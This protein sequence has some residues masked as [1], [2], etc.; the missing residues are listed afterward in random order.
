MPIKVGIVGLGWAGQQHTKVLASLP[1]AKIVAFADL[2]PERVA[3]FA[4]QH[5][6]RAYGHWKDMLG[7]EPE[8]DAVILATPAQVRLEPIEA[9]AA[10]KIALFCEK[11]PALDVAT[12]LK[13]A[14]AIRRAGIINS[15]GFQYRWAPP[16]QRMRE[17]IAGRP[18]LFARIAVAWPVFDWVRDG[19]APSHLYSK[20]KSGGPLIE[21]GI[22]FQDV[23]RYIT[24]DEPLCL[25]AMAELG[26]TQPREGRDS[27]DTTLVLARHQSGMLSTHVQ[28]W[29]H[30]R[31][32]L[33]LQIVGDDFD[34]TWNIANGE[35]SGTLAGE[36]LR[37][38]LTGDPHSE[39]MH[40][41]V[42]AVARR[43]QAIIRSS[44]LDAC[45]SLAACEAA[46]LSISTGLPQMVLPVAGD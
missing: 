37:E 40:G 45:W 29:S 36:P 19:L 31:T 25:H 26:R 33:Q 20:A 46:A 21:Q 7:G 34:L 23:L 5:G 9:I 14:D 43:E 38:A 32:I 3:A 24:E 10:R 28:N 17:L 8:L 2:D 6:A 44:Y 13:A 18:R 42:S 1:E 12:A 16:A 11:P 41:F 39:E 27:E 15:V 30:S 35:L 4:D 22:H